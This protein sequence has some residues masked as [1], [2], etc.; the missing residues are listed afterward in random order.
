L[1]QANQIL[2]YGLSLDPLDAELIQILS[3]ASLKNELRKIIIVNPDYERIK[4]RIKVL[5]HPRIIPI[6]KLDVFLLRFWK[7]KYKKKDL[8]WR[9]K[10][11]KP[12]N[13]KVYRLFLWSRR[14]S[15]PGPNKQLKSFLRVYFLIGFS[16]LS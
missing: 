13:N 6:L 10:T 12:V 16:M 5:L 9:L 8:K 7:T 14:E 4:N 2:I 15:N 1:E 11:K 3:G